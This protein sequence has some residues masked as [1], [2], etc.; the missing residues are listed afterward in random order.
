M[1]TAVPD[2]YIVTGDIT[3]YAFFAD[4]SKVAGTYYLPSDGNAEAYIQLNADGTYLYRFGALNFSANYTFDGSKI[5]LQPCPLFTE[6]AESDE[7]T[8]YY[9]ICAAA[10]IEEGTVNLSFVDNVS[11]TANSPLVAV[12]L[13]EGFNYGG[14]YAENGDTNLSDYV[15]YKNGEGVVGT[16][17]FTYTVNSFGT[18]L[19]IKFSSGASINCSLF[20][21]SI[22]IAGVTYNAYDEFKGTW[23]KSAT[24]HKKYTFD[25][26]GGWS[27]EDYKYNTKGE[28]VSVTSASGAYTVE[29][30]ILTLTENNTRASFNNG[31]LNI[32]FG[33]YTEVY[34]KENSFVGEWKFYNV[35]EPVTISL[36]GVGTAGYGVAYV[37]Y[38]SG[39]NSF[40]M[41]YEIVD[42]RGTPSLVFYY[43]D[44]VY[45]ELVFSA[46][47]GTLTGLFYSIYNGVVR[48]DV[49][50]CLMDDLQ[51]VW[52]S[53]ELGTVEF[54]GL[55]SYS[56]AGNAVY[57]R[58]EGKVKI[59]GRTVGN[60][61]LENGTMSGS[62]TY[63]GVKYIVEYN[64]ETKN[65]DVKSVNESEEVTG[66]FELVGLDELV[67]VVL[68][69]GEHTYSFNGG[70][71]LPSGGVLTVSG[72][73][74]VY[75]YF[76][77][78]NGITVKKNGE[79]YGAI[80]MT[81]GVY[82]LNVGGSAKEL[83]VNNVFTGEWIKGGVNGGNVVI[84]KINGALK[85]A[86]TYLGEQVEYTYNLEK[87]Y[88]S[89]TYKTQT[90]YVLSMKTN[91]GYELAIS[92]VPNTGSGFEVCIKAEARDSLLGTYT[93]ADGSA[94][95]LDGFLTSSYANGGTA[96]L[97]D[98]DGKFVAS[99]TYTRNSLNEIQFKGDKTLVFLE[100][101]SGAEGAYVK[102]G[103]SYVLVETDELYLRSSADAA[104]IRYTFNG[105]GKV[106]ATNG[107][108]FDYVI[109]SYDEIR[110]EYKLTFTNGNNE[111]AVVYSR[112]SSIGITVSPDYLKDVAAYAPGDSNLVYVFD[113]KG[114]VTFSSSAG[115]NKDYKY[116]IN[117][118]NRETN[119]YELTF[120]DK[121]SKDYNAVYSVVGNTVT[122]TSVE[123]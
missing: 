50:F 122:V 108:V 7:G 35:K 4:Y 14:Y 75:A 2:S 80:V 8:N 57:A 99:Y 26:K 63:N 110:Y 82:T 96:V 102:D 101:E 19:T 1:T 109:E 97:K 48:D 86:G 43:G 22:V 66:Q 64:E 45:G 100:A 115:D 31:F 98:K 73:E 62:F 79:D 74:N 84:G 111:Y 11:F 116:V 94:V 13:I 41:N 23:E 20:Q 52:V 83:S 9:N 67:S 47:N 76:I 70:G 90:L 29:N 58:T 55:G 112:N 56:L 36:E 21:N 117:A 32:D 34:Y 44:V 91:S 105:R 10:V 15:F 18:G 123:P 95:V 39:S 93:A 53:T 40:E 87:N 24:T 3:L 46:E 28:K 85:A 103:A 107:M 118:Y 38:G 25:G 6:S 92:L 16:A 104:G 113:G 69:D 114:T 65:I 42:N 5:L 59:N 106:T 68:T 17:A 121:D 60:Y 27:Y 49:L 89:F 119:S 12:K 120:T 72:D 77:G 37:V 81:D 61:K 71:N 33:N 30:G 51:G 78:E 88:L 54:N